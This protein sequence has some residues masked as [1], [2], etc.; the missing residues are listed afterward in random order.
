[1]SFDD[2]VGWIRRSRRIQHEQRAL[3]LQTEKAP[4]RL[5]NQNNS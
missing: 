1:M 2:F 4:K 5:F 3:C